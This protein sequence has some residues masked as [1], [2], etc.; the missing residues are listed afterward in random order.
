MHMPFGHD[1]SASSTGMS[2]RPSEATPEGA[3][4]RDIEDLLKKIDQPQSLDSLASHVRRSFEVARC[5]RQ[6]EGVDAELNMSFRAYNNQYEPEEMDLVK[7]ANVYMG[8]TNLK[9][10]ALQSWV[11]D[12]LAN[13]EDKPWTLKPTPLAELPAAAEE[14]VV[15]RL[16]QEIMEHGRTFDLKDRA[17]VLKS[18]AYHHTQKLAGLAVERMERKIQDYMVEGGWRTAFSDYVVDLSIFPNA[19]LKGPVV[20]RRKKL[21]WDG[22]SLTAV[23][24]A[25]YSACR[26]SPYDIYPSPNSTTTQNGAYIIERQRLSQDDL[27]GSIGM[28]GFQEE[29]IRYLIAAYPNGTRTFGISTTEETLTRTDT[30]AAAPDNQYEC[31]VYYG[32]LPARLLNEYG[33]YPSDLQAMPESEVWVCNDRVIRAVLNPHPLGTRPI[34]SSSFSNIPGAFWGRSLPKLLRDVQRV[35]NA[36]ARALVRN[37]AFS[38]GPIGEYD[39]N[40]LANETNIEEVVPYRM[41]AIETDQFSQTTQPAIKFNMVPSVARQVMQVYDAHAK[42]ADDISGIPAYILG[43]PQVA[44][45]GRTMGGLAMLMGNAAKGVKAV[46]ADVDKQITEPLVGSFYALIMMY[47]EDRTVKADAAVVARGSSGLLQKELSQARAVEVLQ[48]L[49]PYMQ[50]GLVPKEGLQLVIRDVLRGLGYNADEIVPD[51]MRGSKLSALGDALPGQ[52]T[53]AAQLDGRSALQ[54]DPSNA[55]IP[56]QP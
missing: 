33:L 8:I 37:M 20:S 16:M 31:L 1:T 44:G 15:D 49:T 5:H 53:P 12:I 22:N 30:D 3:A 45:A 47:D 21:R 7:Q 18:V 48:M 46:I 43:N 4:M 41:Y 17:G 35:A 38:A 28:A 29:A 6:T 9:C 54:P 42:Y 14:A 26:V 36:S 19:F 2:Y 11:K 32:K 24:T 25:C 40:R 56:P 10:R 52:P 55:Q 51:P 39:I 50:T 34:Y 27:M 13:N 23:Y